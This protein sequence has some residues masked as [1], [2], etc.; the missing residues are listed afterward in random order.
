MKKLIATILLTTVLISCAVDENLNIDQKNPKVVSGDGLFT[1]GTRDLFDYI[2]SASVNTNVFRLYAQYWAQTTYPDESQFN[3]TT[4]NL[5]D[6]AFRD[7]YRDVLAD[8][9]EAKTIFNKENNSTK[10]AVTEVIMIY[11]YATLVDIFG[12]VP[13]T[14]A[15]DTNNLFPKFDDDREIYLDL[16][17]RLNKAINTLGDKNISKLMDPVYEGDVTLWKK[18]ANSLK[19]RLALRF[20]SSDP[21]SST[22]KTYIE[23]AA[24]SVITSN[25]ENFGINY[26]G[27]A[28]NT[29]PLWVD[30]VQSGRDDFV[31]SDTMIDLMN[32]LK[33]PRLKYY[34]ST[35]K[36]KYVGGKYGKANSSSLF[37]G[38]SDVLK[39]PSLKGCGI[40]YSEVEF[41]LTEAVERGFNVGGTAQ[42]HYE[43]AVTASIE[44][45]GGTTTD[46]KVY[47][48]EADVTYNS[49]NWEKIVATQKWIALFNNGIEGW[50]TYRLFDYPVLK[51][52]KDDKGNEIPV[53]TRFLY[54]TNESSLNGENKTKAIEAMGMNKDSKNGKIFWDKK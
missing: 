12:N 21:A 26:Y 25:T 51:K 14:E 6:N 38:L 35:V 36:G 17:N 13:Y 32:A 10:S 48:K 31:G 8:L 44:Q 3:Q 42:E 29:N 46:A 33:D 54:P 40:S 53:P 24:K 7:L 23:E 2:N 20:D 18:A 28:P 5:P 37:S 1:N 4:R 52:L 39:K 47:L 50:T 15:L 49:A 22:I 16:L 45:W 43:K 41:L 34:F 11:T 27:T 30:L 19:L 9:K